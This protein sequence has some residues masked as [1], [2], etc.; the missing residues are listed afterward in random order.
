MEFEVE[1]RTGRDGRQD[2]RCGRTDEE[3]RMAERAARIVLI[4]HHSFRYSQ[5]PDLITYPINRASGSQHP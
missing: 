4:C 3:S 1:G 5:T 2:G